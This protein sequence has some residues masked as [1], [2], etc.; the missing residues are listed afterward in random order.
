MLSRFQDLYRHSLERD[1]EERLREKLHVDVRDSGNWAI[2]CS[3]PRHCNKEL[4]HRSQ[5]DQWDSNLLSHIVS[6][7]HKQ[8]HNHLTTT[9]SLSN[10]FI[11]PKLSDKKDSSWSIYL[12]FAALNQ[13][14]CVGHACKI[15]LH[16]LS[17]SYFFHVFCLFPFQ[18]MTS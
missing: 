16:L 6:Q 1:K 8:Y 10:I 14:Q 12:A 2:F 3:F 9:L 18:G 11:F 5:V 13:A 4:S 7:C 15:H 17:V